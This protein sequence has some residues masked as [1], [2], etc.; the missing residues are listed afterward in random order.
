MNFESYKKAMILVMDAKVLYDKLQDP[1]F[2]AFYDADV[3]KKNE[4]LTFDEWKPLALVEDDAATDEELKM[5]FEK[6]KH[7]V[8]EEEAQ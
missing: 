2:K 3:G 4:L 1:Q 7:H 6:A 5:I 8:A